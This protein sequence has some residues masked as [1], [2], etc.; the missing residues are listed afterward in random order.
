M[1]I[2]R[3]GLFTEGKTPQLANGFTPAAGLQ[4]IVV[5]LWVITCLADCFWAKQFVAHIAI[6]RNKKR[7]IQNYFINYYSINHLAQPAKLQPRVCFV[8]YSILEII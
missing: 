7:V 5:R 4:T 2:F 1:V 6:K 3:T 8:E